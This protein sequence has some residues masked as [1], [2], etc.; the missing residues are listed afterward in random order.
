MIDG[1]QKGTGN[2]RYLKSVS[3]L[4]TLY[5]TYEN[6]IAALIAGTFPIDLNGINSSGWTQLG[7]PFTKANL[8]S[9]AVSSAIFDDSDDHTVNEALSIINT[10]KAPLA[11]PTFTGTPTAPTAAIGTITT[12]LA[13]T[14]FVEN[15]F[16]IGS[17]VGTGSDYNFITLNATPK[18][19][20]VITTE[21]NESSSFFYPSKYLALAI[22]GHSAYHNTQVELSIGDGGFYAYDSSSVSGMNYTK[23][24]NY[25]AIF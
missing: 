22:T 9:D 12:Q 7:T 6:F 11:S 17:Y 4:L 10:V 16:S 8:L 18:A 2:S 20:L 23:N 13:T 19:V 24:Y 5:P 21:L 15:K 14:A 3:N 25:I 1:T